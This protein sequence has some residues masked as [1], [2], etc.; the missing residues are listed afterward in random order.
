MALSSWSSWLRSLTERGPRAQRRGEHE[1]LGV[2]EPQR[3][4]DGSVEGGHAAGG[5]D[6]RVAD[7]PVERE[8]VLQVL[9]C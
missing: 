7:L 5:D 9:R 2:G 4:E 1:V 6:E 3:V 8:R